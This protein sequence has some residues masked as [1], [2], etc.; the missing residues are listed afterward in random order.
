M[1]VL[2]ILLVVSALAAPA[3][4]KTIDITISHVARVVDGNLV[5]DSKVGN[6]GDE[7]ALSVTPILRF[8]DKEVRGK[9]KPAL[10]PNASFDETLSLPVGT[11]GEG[12]WPYHLT[13]DY[14][15]L[16]QYSLQALQTQA[17]VVGSPPPPKIAVPAIQGG[18]ISGTGT[19]AITV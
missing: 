17:L 3:A 11:L 8:G 6:S 19:L 1:Q 16:N 5:V 18:D 15:D 13:V 9:E 12:R 10:D 7:A 4:A 2:A 14:T